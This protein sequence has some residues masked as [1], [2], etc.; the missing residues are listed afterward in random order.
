MKCPDGPGG[1]V[2]LAGLV[3]LVDLVGARETGRTMS[4]AFRT[5]P[6][7]YTVPVV[8]IVVGHLFGLIPKRWDPIERIGRVL[9][10]TRNTLP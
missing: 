10:S 6:R 5:A 3:A 7:I 2:A 1:W 8:F 4:S 9:I